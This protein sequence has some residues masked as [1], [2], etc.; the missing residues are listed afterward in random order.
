MLSPLHMLVCNETWYK[1]LPSS[2]C[3]L[4]IHRENVSFTYL[5]FCAFFTCGKY[6]FEKVVTTFHHFL[7][8]YLNFF[9]IFSAKN[10]KKYIFV[11]FCAF[12]LIFTFK[13]VQ[14]ALF[15]VNGISLSFFYFFLNFFTTKY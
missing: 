2:P 5:Y 10:Q 8:P 11:L 6:N 12:F 3:P 9:G 4:T 13:K 15:Q 1:C 14:Q 7:G